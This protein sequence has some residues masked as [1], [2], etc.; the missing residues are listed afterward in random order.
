MGDLTDA[1]A[2]VLDAVD[3]EWV[4]DRLCRLIAVPSIGGTPAESEVQHL[5]AGWLDELGCDVDTWQIDL[6]AAATEPDAPG[7]EVRRDEAWV[8]V[9]TLPAAEDGVPPWSSPATRTSSR[10]ATCPCGPA[11]RSCR[12]SRTARSTP[13]ARVT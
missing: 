8:V 1:E 7:Q 5:L 13:A 3:E 11:T 9:G 12:G 10:R 6:A 4:V 2:R